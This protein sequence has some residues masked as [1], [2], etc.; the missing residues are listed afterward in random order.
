MLRLLWA[1]F[2]CGL[3][4]GG[5]VAEGGLDLISS[6]VEGVVPSRRRQRSSLAPQ[7][8]G[9]LNVLFCV[10]RIR[11]D[12]AYCCGHPTGAPMNTLAAARTRSPRPHPPLPSRWPS[13]KKISLLLQQKS[14]GQPARPLCVRPQ[15]FSEASIPN[16]VPP[17]P[18]VSALGHSAFA[19]HLPLGV[20]SFISAT[21]H[22]L[23]VVCEGHGKA[24]RKFRT[25]THLCDSC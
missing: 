23:V 24:V 18:G 7:L 12:A 8:M 19:D 9:F 4:R 25:R 10:C 5:A 17:C 22:V 1:L 21:S 6:G 3:W 16:S 15:T 11:W 13:H 14:S 2:S 20:P